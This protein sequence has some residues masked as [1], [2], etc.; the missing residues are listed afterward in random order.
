MLVFGLGACGESE[1]PA[2]SVGPVSYTDEQLLGLSD[3]RRDLLVGLTALGLSVADSTTAELGQPQI[4]AWEDDR[5]LD[6]LAAE[7][8]LEK[9]GVSDEELRGHYEGDP[10]WALTVQHLLVFS[11]RWRPDEHRQAAHAKASRGRDLLESGAGF[12]EVEAEL[13]EDGGAEAREGTLPAS[14]EADL[15]PEFWQ[16]ALVLE[17]GEL[18][19]VTETQYG[20]H[21]LRLLEREQVPFAEARST[22]VREVAATIENP[23]AVLEA[24]AETR[25][26]DD[27]SRRDAAVTEAGARGLELSYGDRAELLRR[28][29]TDVLSWSTAF[30]FRYGLFAEE[31]GQA[32]LAALASTGQ[33]ADIARRELSAHLGTLREHYPVTSGT[34]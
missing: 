12:A 30:G 20:F 5:I 25:G 23:R 16:A 33:L 1:P 10:D 14:R 6:V 26:G 17:P 4:A 8:T 9:N 2:L 7:L 18:S 15:V 29:E 11:A 3:S 34:P 32:A 13:A 21:V 22:V 31:V 28:W 27:T 24:W 19:P